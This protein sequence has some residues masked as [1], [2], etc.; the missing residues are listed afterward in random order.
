[1]KF[2]Y[3]PLIIMFMNDRLLDIQLN[4][5]PTYMNHCYV[6]RK[7]HSDMQYLCDYRIKIFVAKE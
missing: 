1:M 6:R 2:R 5:I 4:G 3:L 7:L